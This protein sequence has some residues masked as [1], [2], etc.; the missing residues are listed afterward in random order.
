MQPSLEE[1]AKEMLVVLD[2]V[3]SGRAA[4]VVADGV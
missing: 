3:G 2:A 1:R 4:V